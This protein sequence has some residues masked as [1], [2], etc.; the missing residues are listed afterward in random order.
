MDDTSEMTQ[1]QF[2]AE[3][4]RRFGHRSWD[5]QFVCPG[6][7]D[8]A[9]PKDFSILGLDS[10]LAGRV[11]L[12]RVAIVLDPDF[13]RGCMRSTYD[14]PQGPWL[15]VIPGVPGES[16]AQKVPSFALALVE[17]PY[18]EP[19]APALSAMD[20]W[21][22]DNEVEILSDLPH[23]DRYVLLQCGHWFEEQVPTFRYWSFPGPHER[24][25]CASEHPGMISRV[26]SY[27]SQPY[28][29]WM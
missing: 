14:D 3:A 18:V 1:G 12:G 13:N 25:C 15:I 8:V 7:G 4:V 27:V 2:C 5:W 24:A 10:T 6:C 23:H 29:G 19:A 26:V 22:E 16:S 28:D 21:V 20:Q 9:T 17:H 11:C